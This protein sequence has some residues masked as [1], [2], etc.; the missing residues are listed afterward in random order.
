MCV[1]EVPLY[2]FPAVFIRKSTRRMVEQAAK[3]QFGAVLVALLRHLAESRPCVASV[4]LWENCC[5]G[6]LYRDPQ[7]L[8]A[9]LC[10]G[11]APF[12]GWPALLH[13]LH[14]LRYDF[15][16]ARCS[17][18]LASPFRAVLFLDDYATHR[19]Y[20]WLVPIVLGNLPALSVGATPSRPPRPRFHHEQKHPCGR[21]FVS[22]LRQTEP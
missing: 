22:P 18:F 1:T 11:L 2:C 17:F 14:L 8:T 20:G 5:L 12:P 21:K 15:V 9:E 19:P 6:F 4:P 7:A 3:P 10:R 16:A 13:L